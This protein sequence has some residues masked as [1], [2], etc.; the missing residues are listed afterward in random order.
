MKILKPLLALPFLACTLSAQ[1]ATYNVSGYLT[2][3][4]IVIPGM[5]TPI[6]THLEPDHPALSGQLSISNTDQSIYYT[7]LAVGYHNID[8]TALGSGETAVVTYPTTSVLIGTQYATSYDPTTRTITGHG[9]IPKLGMTEFCVGAVSLCSSIY[10][11]DFFL[12]S[13]EVHG[14]VLDL[15]LTFS[16]DF[17]Q[18]TAQGFLTLKLDNGASVIQNFV[19]STSPITPPSVPLPAAGWLLGSGLIGL[20]GV[21]RRL[22]GRS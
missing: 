19:F 22:R 6:V 14:G 10:T 9:A 15:I 4:S 13:Y 11:S 17:S 7:S 2:S 16:P 21:G 5:S 3:A 1:A 18:F 12:K 8:V 20:A